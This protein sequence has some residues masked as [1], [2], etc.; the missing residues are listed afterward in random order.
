MLQLIRDKTSG[1]IATAIMALLIIPFAFWGINYY[2]KGGGEIIVASVDG[3]HVNL[4]KFQRTLD[5]FRQQ[6][7]SQPGLKMK[8]NEGDEEALKKLTLDKLVENELLNQTTMDYG[9]RVSDEV[10]KET[11]K[12]IDAFKREGGFNREFYRE[13]ISRLGLQPAIYEEQL[14]QDMMSEQLQSAIME[15]DLVSRQSAEYAARLYHQIR[16]LRYTIIPVDKYKNTINVADAEIE[17]FY[18]ENSKLYIKPEQ[19]RIAYLDLKSG[20]LADRVEVKEDALREYYEANK[21]S[22]DEAEQRK[23]NEILIKTGKDATPEDMAA[24]KAR[25]EELLVQVRSGKT[26][27]DIAKLHAED[28]DASFSMQELGLVGKGLL[29]EAVDKVA[30]SMQEGTVSDAIQTDA[31][32]YIIELK[33]IK[34][35]VMNTFEKVRDNVVKDYRLK[36]AEKLFY[37]LA[38][39]LATQ[40]YEHPDT[41]DIAAEQI[42]VPLQQSELLTRNGAGEGLTA[43]QKVIAA[44]FAEDVLANGHNS[45]VLE[46]STDEVVVLRVLEHIPESVLPLAEVRD[47]IVDDIKFLRG[48]ELTEKAGKEILA[49]LRSGKSFEAVAAER[50]ISW[51]DAEGVTRSDVKVN[52]SILRTAFRLG[53]SQNTTP[54]YGSVV[55]GTGDYAVIATLAVR[56]PEPGSIKEDEIR[57]IQRQLQS[58]R[59]AISW[60]D[61]LADIRRRADI[62]LFKDKI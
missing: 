52:L 14:R 13:T 25:A 60:Q 26:F 27:A 37:D 17:K 23:L 61:Y 7:R 45:E 4:A 16:D 9:L 49:D 33:E 18:K 48:S 51:Q 56:D 55:M 41:L 43:N 57:N 30:F 40:S 11:I 6:I 47:K 34:G 39:E 38:D 22:Y 35:G 15:S 3:K 58:M 8:I 28:K 53:R 19:V 36:Q 42:G 10:I 59:S 50:N 2:F 20:M 24:A 1:W 44:S 21:T 32:I 5:N 62:K 31:G 46:I 29:P 12:N 54:L